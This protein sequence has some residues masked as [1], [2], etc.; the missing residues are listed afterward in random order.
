MRLPL[1]PRHHAAILNLNRRHLCHPSCGHGREELIERST[2]EH[3]NGAPY[4]SNCSPC[5]RTD[6]CVCH[7]RVCRTTCPRNG[8]RH[9]KRDQHYYQSGLRHWRFVRLT[10]SQSAQRPHFRSSC[11]DSGYLLDRTACGRATAIDADLVRPKTLD[12]DVPTHCR[13][14]GPR[15]SL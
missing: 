11:S 3:W 14:C 6:R 15:R 13:S 2:G 8:N 9:R 10:S 4:E 5:H 12:A 7:G 1:R